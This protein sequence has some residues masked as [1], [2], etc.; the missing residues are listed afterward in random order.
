[1]KSCKI[2]SFIPNFLL[3]IYV[4]VG[5]SSSALLLN[6]I[7]SYGYTK[8]CYMLVEISVLFF[9]NYILIFI[10]MENT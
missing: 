3:L 1:M 5:S 8:I 4:F 10:V 7:L 9:Q 2:Y 6:S